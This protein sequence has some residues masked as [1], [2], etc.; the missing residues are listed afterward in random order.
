MRE[1]VI[2]R[3]SKVPLWEKYLLSIPEAS[4][5]FGI[6]AAKL[7]QIV[8]ENPSADYVFWNGTRAMIKRKILEKYID[9]DLFAV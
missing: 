5:Y 4:E 7:R 8:S 1:E 3:N 9:E 6:G 2:V